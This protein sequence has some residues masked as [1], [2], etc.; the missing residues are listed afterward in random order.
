MVEKICHL[1]LKMKVCIKNTL[2]SGIKLKTH[3][4]QDFIVN[5]FMMTNTQKLK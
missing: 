1:K 3:K 2:K 4:M 5:I